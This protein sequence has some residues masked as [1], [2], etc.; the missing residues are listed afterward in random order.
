MPNNDIIYLDRT[1]RSGNTSSWRTYASMYVKGDPPRKSPS[2]DSALM[3]ANDICG[4]CSACQSLRSMLNPTSVPSAVMPPGDQ[5]CHC[6]SV[7]RGRLLLSRRSFWTS[8]T[9]NVVVALSE[10][11]TMYAVVFDIVAFPPANTIRQRDTVWET[12]KPGGVNVQFVLTLT[13]SPSELSK[14]KAVVTKYTR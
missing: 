11:A 6:A 10:H 2:T 9:S 8:K 14:L 1:S 12:I 4:E 13:T 7:D 3:M 5:S